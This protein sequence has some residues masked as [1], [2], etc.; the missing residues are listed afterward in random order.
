MLNIRKTNINDFK[1]L[2]SL[3]LKTPE[4]KVNKKDSFMDRDDFKL[5]ILDKKHIFLVAEEDK[6][7]AGFI[8][9]SAKDIERP[10]KNKYA[11]LVY[12][13]VLPE[14]RKRG[15]ATKLYNE[16]VKKLKR[17]GI[18][19]IYAWAD[20]KSGIINFLKKRGFDEGKP[21]VWM[22]RKL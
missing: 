13:A 19:H 11:C 3:G 21:S 9:A 16:C 6:K 17:R 1:Q 20:M 7:I 5:R 10:L 18:T 4:L 12:I 2:Y 14:Y 22:D 15:I 8:C